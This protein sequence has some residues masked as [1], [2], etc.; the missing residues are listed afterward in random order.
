M[1]EFA[2]LYFGQ[3][4]VSKNLE[5]NVEISDIPNFNELINDKNVLAII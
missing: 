5:F 3:E 4:I 1:R 2:D